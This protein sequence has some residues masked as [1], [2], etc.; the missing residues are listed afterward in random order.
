MKSAFWPYSVD[1]Y[2]MF[3]LLKKTPR[4]TEHALAKRFHVNDKTAQN[5]W[6]AALERK[7]LLAPEFRKK[8][9][10]NFEEYFYYLNVKDP[11]ERYEEL[12]EHEEEIK[13]DI[14]HFSV[15]TGFCN[16][17][18]VSNKKINPKGEIVLS[19]AR[20]DYFLTTPR[21]STFE[22][23]LF[24]IKS[25]LSSIEDTEIQPSPL[26]YHETDYE[27]WDE[28]DE[29]IYK[30]LSENLRKPFKTVLRKTGAKRDKILDWMKK[31]SQFG[32]TLV[33]YF[34]KGLGAYQPVI[35]CVDT[36]CDSLLIDI[37]SSLPVPTVFYRI[38]EKLM[39]KV[40]LQN[41]SLEGKFTT[42]KALSELRK[43]ELV[44]DYTNSVVQYNYRI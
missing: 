34:P 43:K 19:G 44:E 8:A 10:K 25:K 32:H 39:V 31:R 42:N 2:D 12:I 26:I 17:Q 27:D 18:I 6:R 23:S 13:D 22:E 37:F 1:T 15:Q 4:I 5:W 21:N 24:L 29:R 20:S 33:M 14:L 30:E 7:I 3:L 35:Y 9:F 11:H 36:S 16:F 28:Y 41:D 40:Y 38:K